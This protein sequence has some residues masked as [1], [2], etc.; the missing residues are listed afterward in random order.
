MYE[1]FE[2][3]MKK[4]GLKYAQISRETGISYSTF[5]DWKA[6]RAC[7][8]YDKLKK[9]AEYFGVSVEYLMGEEEKAGYYLNPET[10]RVA[11]EIFENDELRAFFD[12]QKDLNPLDNRLF[13]PL[14]GAFVTD[15]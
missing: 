9:I 7:P 13:P 6:G 8:K 5:T 1:I 14:L 11:Q 3:L 15:L 2:S 10:A 12:V 4:R